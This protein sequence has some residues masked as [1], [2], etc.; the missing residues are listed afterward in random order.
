MK[1]VGSRFWTKIILTTNAV[2]ILNPKFICLPATLIFHFVNTLFATLVWMNVFIPVVNMCRQIKMFAGDVATFYSLAAEE[3]YWRHPK[4]LSILSQIFPKL[5]I[6]SFRCDF[7]L[8][9]NIVPSN[10]FFFLILRPDLWNLLPAPPLSLLSK[11]FDSGKSTL[12]HSFV[13]SFF[14]IVKL[15]ITGICYYGEDRF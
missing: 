9:F 15:L 4:N 2:N 13:W 14:Q 8:I 6:F 11:K 7:F 12:C 10:Y 1:L 5:M 3:G